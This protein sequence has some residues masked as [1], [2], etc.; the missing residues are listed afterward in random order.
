MITDRSNQ[1]IVFFD[2]VCGLC[3]SA[4]DFLMRHDKRKVL[5]FAPLQGDTAAELLP[6]GEASALSSMAYYSD[7]RISYRTKAILN[8]LWDMGG[9][10]V[11]FS[12]FR[13]I[14]AFIRDIFYNIMAASRYKWFGKKETCRIPTAEER[15][16]FLD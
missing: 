12:I 4:I 13:I 8:M 16:R 1:H 6:P 7:G 15:G 10:W 3:N 14:P 2:G 5:L 9:W 11:I